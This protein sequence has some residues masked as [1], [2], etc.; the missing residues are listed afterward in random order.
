MHDLSICTSNNN[1]LNQTNHRGDKGGFVIKTS[2][3]GQDGA[4]AAEYGPIQ[5]QLANVNLYWKSCKVT[6]QWCH[7]L[8]FIKSTLKNL[9]HIH[10]NKCY[11]KP[12]S[13]Y[14]MPWY[15]ACVCGMR[16]Y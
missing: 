13:L 3:N 8:I 9:I 12:N 14:H 1:V 5:Q 11:I 10:Y 7:F 15:G 4:Q 6:A 16:V 2:S